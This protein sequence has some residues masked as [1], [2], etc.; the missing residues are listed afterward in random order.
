[1]EKK[2][3]LTL[4]SE[5]NAPR[6]APSKDAAPPEDIDADAPPPDAPPD[7]TE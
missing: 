4:L 5:V 1:M 2:L 3:A 7:E 6:A